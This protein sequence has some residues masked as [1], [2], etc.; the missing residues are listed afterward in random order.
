MTVA[1]DPLDHLDRDPGLSPRD[2]QVFRLVRKDLETLA[3]RPLKL[4][5]LAHLVNADRQTVQR[6]LRR[7]V[8]H[9]YLEAAQ[10]VIGEG[11]LY[12]LGPVIRS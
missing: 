7:L 9:G 1:A 6:S 5:H 2:S 10:V 3:F 4:R 12:R 11:R 8:A